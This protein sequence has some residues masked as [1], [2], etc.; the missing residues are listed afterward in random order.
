MKWECPTASPCSVDQ[1]DKI[2]SGF[3]KQVED[4]AAQ[5]FQNANNCVVMKFIGP[6]KSPV[7]LIC[8]MDM[9]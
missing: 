8:V 1:Y 6:E 3:K 4:V 9:N 5:H 7:N 2:H